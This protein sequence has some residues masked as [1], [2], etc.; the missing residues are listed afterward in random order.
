MG[1]IALPGAQL[2]RP[3]AFLRSVPIH[4][5]WQIFMFSHFTHGLI[6]LGALGALALLEF[7][8]SIFLGRAIRSGR[9]PVPKPSEPAKFL[10]DAGSEHKKTTPLI[11]LRPLQRQGRGGQEPGVANEELP[12]E[13]AAGKADAGIFKSPIGRSQK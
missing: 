9:R 2:S 12:A 8:F 1:Q 10:V 6:L 4:R 3:P 13:Q 11:A 5:T 7:V